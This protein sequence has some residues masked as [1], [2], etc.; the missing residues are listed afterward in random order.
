[1]NQRVEVKCS[2]CDASFS[3]DLKPVFKVIADK[4][5]TDAKGLFELSDRIFLEL[6]KTFPN[7]EE[8]GIDEMQTTSAKK[9]LST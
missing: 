1:M 5:A 3:I 2:K 9:A 4:L 8:G 7:A 6:M